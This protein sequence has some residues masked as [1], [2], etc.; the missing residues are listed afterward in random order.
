MLAQTQTQTPH[1]QGPYN[2]ITNKMD[3]GYYLIEG[4]PWV[5]VPLQFYCTVPVMFA[6]QENIPV[7][8]ICEYTV[9]YL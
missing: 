3:F 7:Q 8:L 9:L 4:E 6:R 2:W 5:T 1:V